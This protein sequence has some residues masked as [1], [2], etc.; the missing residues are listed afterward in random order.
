MSRFQDGEYMDL[1][2]DGSPDAYYI[3]GHVTHEQGIEILEAQTCLDDDEL[4]ALGRAVQKYGRWSC[5]GDRVE[6][7][8]LVLREYMTLGKGRFKITHFGVGIFTKQALKGG[9]VE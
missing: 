6:G 1:I 3:K 5:Q 7:C 4:E 8:S 2:W 9:E